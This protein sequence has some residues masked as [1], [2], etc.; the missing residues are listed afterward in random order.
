MAD[1]DQDQNWQNEL[2][3]DPSSGFSPDRTDEAGD[4]FLK[5][6]LTDY[7]PESVV[8]G[9]DKLSASLDAADEAFDRTVQN[10]LRQYHPPYDPHAWSHFARRFSFQRH[11]RSR[12]ILLKVSEAVAV[13]LLLFTALQLRELKEQ[14]S[15]LDMAVVIPDDSNA[16]LPSASQKEE[17]A[18]ITLDQHKEIGVNQGNSVI[19]EK[20]SSN[21]SLSPSREI[22]F[23]PLLDHLLSGKVVRRIE[24]DLAIPFDEEIILE[25]RKNLAA[26]AVAESQ[27]MD[28]IAISAPDAVS[29]LP[30]QISTLHAPAEE[31]MIASVVPILRAPRKTKYFEFGM[32]VQGDYNQLKMP[33]DKVN[34]NAKQF[35]F[36]L[37]G[38]TSPGYGAGLTFAISHPRW[39][40]ETGAI[41]N[42][43]N[44]S[45]DR[46]VI[47]E[48]A[49]ATSNVELEKM[50]MQ[51]VSIP[52]QFRY[53]LNAQGKV[54]T[55]AQ[56][57]FGM[58]MI[59]QSHADVDVD[60]NFPTLVEGEDPNA[61]PALQRTIRQTQ[62]ASEDLREQAPFSTKSLISANI[63]LGVEYDLFEDKTIFIQSIYQYQIPNL[64]FQSHQG[65]HLVTLSIQAG[66]RAPISL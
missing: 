36:P 33:G 31:I 39:A 8:R 26:Y 58:H 56:A 63:G 40:I 9:W 64:R 53:K 5:Q 17:I 11:L 41:Y 48:D 23:T 62:R 18:A 32:L 29:F 66:V 44:F 1:N 35:T 54:R 14:P 12:L 51:F 59:M 61:D 45:P 13:V 7:S 43:K 16:T 46:E 52:L 6:H 37:Q 38:L 57:G 20:I 28:E 42:A 60:Y 24:Q 22:A 50:L 47:V 34:T 2:S 65:K 21:K 4:E 10:K 49:L 27:P 19:Q 55:Y 3:E 30:G 25:N 15:S